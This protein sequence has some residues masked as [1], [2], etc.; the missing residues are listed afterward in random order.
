V[1]GVFD[2]FVPP[3]ASPGEELKHEPMAES[4]FVVRV[5]RS[6][7]IWAGQAGERWPVVPPDASRR[8][9]R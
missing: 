5:V 2:V 8:W 1:L 6:G 4:L 7:G 3:L 9:L